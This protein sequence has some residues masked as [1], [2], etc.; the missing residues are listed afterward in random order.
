LKI[1]S[2]IYDRLKGAPS[3]ANAQVSVGTTVGGDTIVAARTGR[4]SVTIV[5]HGATAVYVGTGTVS[6]ANGFLLPGVAGAALTINT[7]AAVKG[8]TGGG[9]QTV[10]VLEEYE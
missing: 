10:G 5:N 2:G 4:R 9:S 3:V 6:I 1:L 7:T 8:I